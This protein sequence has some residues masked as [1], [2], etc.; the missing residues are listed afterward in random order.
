[1]VRDQFAIE[2]KAWMKGSWF[3]TIEAGCQH[4]TLLALIPESWM[5]HD[6]VNSF[7]ECDQE[8]YVLFIVIYTVFR[9]FTNSNGGASQYQCRFYT[10]YSKCWS[11]LEEMGCTNPTS[12]VFIWHKPGSTP[13]F[14][15]MLY[16]DYCNVS[17]F[18]NIILNQCTCW[19]GTVLW[20]L[21][22]F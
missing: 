15:F 14:Q 5:E 7:W 12:N 3:S 4:L 1:M 11:K 21:V 20:Q 22:F 6:F 8:T 16:P 13:L 9:T 17:S 19:G 18:P 10:G 2:G